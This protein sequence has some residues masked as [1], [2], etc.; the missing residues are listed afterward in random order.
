MAWIAVPAEWAMTVPE[1]VQAPG[2]AVLVERVPAVRAALAAVNTAAGRL[3]DG[4]LMSA[5]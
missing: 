5:P 4:G 2:L 3:I 1:L